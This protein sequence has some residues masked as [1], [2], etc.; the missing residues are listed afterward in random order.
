M[1]IILSETK[2]RVEPVGQ[3]VQAGRVEEEGRDKAR[4]GQWRLCGGTAM[5][6]EIVQISS[7]GKSL[8][9]ITTPD[10]TSPVVLRLD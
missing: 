6:P 3:K 1:E 8:Q 5:A 4:K 2:I 10:Y 9:H 7:L